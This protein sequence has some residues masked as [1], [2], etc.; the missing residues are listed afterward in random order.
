MS[1]CW[2]PFENAGTTAVTLIRCPYQGNHQQMTHCPL[3]HR[4]VEI[5]ANAD[6]SRLKFA[7]RAKKFEGC[8]EDSDI[9][10]ILIKIKAMARR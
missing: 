4:S 10:Q 2:T 7:Q 9:D 1:P 5:P 3:T 6:E 8:Y